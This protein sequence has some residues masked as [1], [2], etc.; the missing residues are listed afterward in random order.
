MAVAI[1]PEIERPPIER[2]MFRSEDENAISRQ[3]EKE[4]PMSEASNPTTVTNGEA[5]SK[6]ESMTGAAKTAAAKLTTHPKVQQALGFAKSHPLGA[7]ATVAA[8]AALVEIEF[9]VG[10][11]TGLGATALL[12]SKSGPEAREQVIARGRKAIARARGAIAKR[13]TTAAP[14]ISGEATPP[15]AR[16]V[17]PA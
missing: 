17:P 16:A 5:A 1:R 7:V 13:R 14:P 4:A 8:A 11:L 15:S 3:V 6:A 10:I 2:R 9:A 12:A